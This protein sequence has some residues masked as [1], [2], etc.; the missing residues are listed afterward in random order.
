MR[1]NGF[2]LN[3]FLKTTV[4]A[5]GGV[6]P[7]NWCLWSLGTLPVVTT[8]VVLL[9]AIHAVVVCTG[10]TVAAREAWGLALGDP[11]SWLTHAFLHGDG[12]H[13][14]YNCIVFWTSGGLIELQLGRARLVAIVVLTIPAAAVMSVIAVPEYWETNANP[15][16]FSAVSLGTF[17]V[18]VYLTTRVLVA[19]LTAPLSNVGAF[20]NVP[21]QRWMILGNVVAALAMLV[22]LHHALVVEWNAMDSAPRV[23]HSFGILSGL[24]VAGQIAVQ[25]SVPLDRPSSKPVV[26]F[27]I[28]I[29]VVVGIEV[30]FRWSSLG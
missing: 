2:G 28:L 6:P 30:G 19:C 25:S 17:V 21:I 7:I 24:T 23:A 18:G 9:C 1:C 29:M 3:A 14:S 13:L 5:I 11:L 20:N 16:G 27:A 26:V 10:G 22:W 4:V 15:I 8:I 12:F